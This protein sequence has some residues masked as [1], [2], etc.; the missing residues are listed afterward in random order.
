MAASGA[1]LFAYWHL[2]R[3]IGLKAMMMVRACTKSA[4]LTAGTAGPLWLASWLHP[5]DEDNFARWGL[6]GGL[7]AVLLWIAGLRL[8][9]HPLWA[10][11]VQVCRRL[12]R[13]P[14][15]TVS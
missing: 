13:R 2:R 15:L 9:A 8:L 5:L 14:D 11:L 1:L 7:V 3:T 4:F 12:L 10:E 6:A